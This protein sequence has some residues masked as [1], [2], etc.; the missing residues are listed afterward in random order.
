MADREPVCERYDVHLDLGGEDGIQHIYGYALVKLTWAVDTAGERLRRAPARP[1]VNDLGDE[2]LEPRLPPH[3]DFWP[4]KRYADVA[5]VGSAWAPEGRPVT[6]MGAGIEVAGRRQG[7]LVVGE[8]RIE[9]DRGRPRIGLAE[10]FTAMPL[11]IERAYGGVDLRVPVD[12]D[13]EEQKLLVAMGADWPGLYPRNPWGR[14]YLAAADA[15]ADVPLPT[16]EDPNDPLTDDRLV[17]DPAAWFTRPLPAYLD[18]T[19]INCFPR[20][21]FL[22]IENEP[23]FPPPADARLPEVRAGLLPEGYREL[24]AEQRFGRRAHWRFRQE[25]APGFFFEP[26]ALAGAPVRVVGLHPERRELRFTLPAPPAVE[27][28]FERVQERV[29]PALTA[30]EIRPDAERVTLTYGARIAAP[31]P[32]VPGIHRHIPL[33]VSI[34]GD[35]PVAYEPPPTTKDRLAAANAE[36]TP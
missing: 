25:A 30:V 3:S 21:L 17:T 33:A 26:T 13:D 22:A 4:S 10:P 5:V 12:P 15:I 35:P 20:N 18:W 14:G 11:G 2:N 7:L 28:R 36:T 6:R 32:F 8:R 24:L 9:F 23:W 31:R 34:D 29:E 19:P 1:L 16:Q 27:M